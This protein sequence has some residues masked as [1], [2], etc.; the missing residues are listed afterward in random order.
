MKPRSNLDSF[1]ELRKYKNDSMESIGM[2]VLKL[3]LFF[4][5]LLGEGKSAAILKLT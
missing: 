1:L 3:S 4:T 5:C 2:F